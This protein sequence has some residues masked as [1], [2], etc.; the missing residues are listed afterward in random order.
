MLHGQVVSVLDSCCPRAKTTK[1]YL[2]IL[3]QHS[4]PI[5]RIRQMGLLCFMMKLRMSEKAGRL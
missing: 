5:R 4:S 3:I 2:S 1:L